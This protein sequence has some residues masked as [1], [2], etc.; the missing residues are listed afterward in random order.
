MV[1]GVLL[2]GLV[3]FLVNWDFY[4]QMPAIYYRALVM[5]NGGLNNSTSAHELA[6]TRT[7]GVVYG[8]AVA[9]FPIAALL[10]SFPFGAASDLLGTRISLVIGMF[11]MA[12]GNATYILPYSSLTLMMTGRAVTGAGSACRVVCLTALSRWFDG[13]ARGAKIG[14]WYAVGMISMIFGPAVAAPLSQAN[15]GAL[16]GQTTAAALCLVL[17]GLLGIL[18]AVVGI[19]PPTADTVGS[20]ASPKPTEGT[21]IQ[22]QPEEDKHAET[23]YNDLPSSHHF[24]SATRL[25]EVNTEEEQLLQPKPPVTEAAPFP[26]GVLVLL[27]YNL[28]LMLG[29][30]TFEATLTPLLHSRF[31]GS[32]LL[33]SLTFAAVGVIA[34]SAAGISGALEKCKFRPFSIIAGGT[35]IFVAGSTLSYDYG[36]SEAASIALEVVA[37]I[38]CSA[39]FT[40]AYVKVPALFAK[41]IVVCGSPVLKMKIGMLMGLLSIGTSVSRVIGPLFLGYGLHIS[42]NFVVLFLVGVLSVALFLVVFS[43]GFLLAADAK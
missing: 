33:A 37:V 38:L 18:I 13:E 28:L 22:K 16:T 3:S 5:E 21:T 17:E 40:A 35:F 10:L 2:L 31:S 41:L 29:V 27:V 20:G 26:K 6:A 8:W 42:T 7:T 39:G 14:Q 25:A 43:R 23:V 32:Q 24:L 11:G 9:S 19:N 15:F 4:S 12:L 1:S 34:F 36:L 30:T